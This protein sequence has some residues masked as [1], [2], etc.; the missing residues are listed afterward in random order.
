V[1]HE[2]NRVTVGGLLKEFP[3]A[4]VERFPY[5]MRDGYVEEIITC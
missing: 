3:E 2:A 4:A 1:N 5:W